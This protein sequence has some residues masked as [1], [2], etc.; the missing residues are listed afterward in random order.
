MGLETVTFSSL[1]WNIPQSTYLKWR[2]TEKPTGNLLR[3]TQFLPMSNRVSCRTWNPVHRE[4]E[5]WQNSNLHVR[6]W[7]PVHRE[8]KVW[9]NS[10]LRIRTWTPVHRESEVWQISDLRVR[11]W[12][13]IHRDSQDWQKLDLHVKTWN[14]VHGNSHSGKTWIS[15]SGHPQGK[16]M[17]YYFY[18]GSDLR[19]IIQ[20]LGEIEMY[21]IWM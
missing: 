1:M 21:R 13:L 12:N 6:T 2:D 3:N 17:Y 7:N 5:V 16:L 19:E 10:D 11:T 20:F 15:V 18:H 8:S 14:P 9:Q 4:S